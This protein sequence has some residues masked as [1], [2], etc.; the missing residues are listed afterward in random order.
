MVW[1]LPLMYQ[2]PHE[3]RNLESKE[4]MEVLTLKRHLSLWR[5]VVFGL[6]LQT[7]LCT[8]AFT[9]SSTTHAQNFTNR[10]LGNNPVFSHAGY[11]ARGAALISLSSK[12]LHVES[13]S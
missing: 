9:D 13:K 6:L 11:L 2:I 12:T 10:L 1:L 5:L 4:R 3:M 7:C 8:S